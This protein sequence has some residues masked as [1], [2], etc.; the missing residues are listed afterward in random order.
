MPPAPADTNKADE[1]WVKDES[2]PPLVVPPATSK[3]STGNAQ[4]ANE[5]KMEP[6]TIPN[7]S[8]GADIDMAA[9]TPQLSGIRSGIF[10]QSGGPIFLGFV[11]SS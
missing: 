9:A 2:V 3:W 5:I 6:N 4:R 10:C 11:F 7:V 1:S 8:D